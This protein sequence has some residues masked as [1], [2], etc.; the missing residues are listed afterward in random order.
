MWTRYLRRSRRDA[1]F[2]H[3]ISSYL[4]IETD[5]NIARGMTP[6]AARAA[7]IRKFGNPTRARENV[8]LM[9]TIGPIDTLWQDLRYALRLLQRDKGFALAAVLSLTLGIGANTA[10]FQLLEAVRLRPLPVPAAHDLAEIRIPPRQ[11]HRDV[12]WPAAAVHLS[13]VG[14]RAAGPA[15]VLGPVRLGRAAVQHRA[16]WRSALRRR[17]VRQRQLLHASGRR[18]AHRTRL[19]A[20]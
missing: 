6:D 18:P 13:D 17:A 7:A 20:R 3:E 2:A 10:I 12:Q 15:G 8:Y 19:H 14:A 11:P 1:D 4:D 16:R 9:N 5:D